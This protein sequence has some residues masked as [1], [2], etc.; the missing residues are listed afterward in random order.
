MLYNESMGELQKIFSGFRPHSTDPIIRIAHRTKVTAP[1]VLPG[2]IVLI[3]HPDLDSVAA[4]GLVRAKPA[5]VINCSPFVTGKYPNQ[6]PKV[7]LA[8]GIPIYESDTNILDSIPDR[9]SGRLVASNL[10]V[11]GIG[12][13][14]LKSV[15]EADINV[16]LASARDN[17]D[18]ELD[19]FVRNTL[20]YLERD[21]ERTLLLDPI[22]PPDVKTDF[23][24]KPAVVAV[25][26]NR[27]R[28]DLRLLAN[29]FADAKPLIIAVDGAADELLSIGLVPDVILGDMDSVSD[30]SLRC[31]AELI[32]HA[33][34]SSTQPVAAPGASRCQQ[35][36]LPFMT[37]PV[38]GTSED[39]A[40]LLAYELG[41]KLIVA[42]GTH[43]HMEDFL[44]KG[45]RGMASTFLVR[46]KVGS[47]LVDAKGVS[48]LM[49]MNQPIGPSLL[50]LVSAALFP[51]IVLLLLT[52]AGQI[53]S[54]SLLL[55]YKAFTA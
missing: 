19:A 49:A 34:A 26:G 54:R 3:A 24:D 51:V 9:S 38:A 27:Y 16:L 47:R 7:L 14:A 29:F 6:G 48:S 33:Y 45:R 35:L 4:E 44:D 2:E 39:A 32:V 37:F 31:G 41:A 8:A 50:L 20:T 40:L 25:R 18:S 23:F 55:V 30:R 52:P 11:G 36:G 22:I 15:S 46:L 13:F 12:S 42:V 53:L 17:L 43:T 28:E 10:V 5:A 1:T 21:S